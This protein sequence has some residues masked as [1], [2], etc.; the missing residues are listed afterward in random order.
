M[1]LGSGAGLHD[2][3][4]NSTAAL[5]LYQRHLANVTDIL[6]ADGAA[7]Q[8]VYALTTPQMQFEV[9]QSDPIVAE[10]NARATA[11]MSA[12]KPKAVPIIDL[13][14]RVKAKCGQTYTKCPGFCDSAGPGGTCTYH[15]T[16]TGYQWIAELMVTEITK[17]L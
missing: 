11:V 13:Y 5:D 4:D 17:L 16:S 10:L 7:K 6:T 14:S 3:G 1:W 9:N 2:L 12:A 8:V 15:Y